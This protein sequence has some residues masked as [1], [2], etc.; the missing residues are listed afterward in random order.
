MGLFDR[1]KRKKDPEPAPQGPALSPTADTAASTPAEIR[2]PIATVIAE[3]FPPV[4]SA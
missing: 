1:F 4:F 2:L 3:S